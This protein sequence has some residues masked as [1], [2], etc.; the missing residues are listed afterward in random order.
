MPR[1]GRLRNGQPAPVSR[2]HA[3]SEI[4][5]PHHQAAA[6]SARHPAALVP[7]FALARRPHWAHMAF[8]LIFTRALNLCCSCVGRS[9]PGQPSRPTLDS[10]LSHRH[11]RQPAAASAAI[12]TRCRQP[13]EDRLPPAT[14]WPASHPKTPSARPE[15]THRD[16]QSMRRTDHPYNESVRTRP[17]STSRTAMVQIAQF[18]LVAGVTAPAGSASLGPGH[19]GRQGSPNPRRAVRERAD[20]CTVFVAGRGSF[21]ASADY[22]HA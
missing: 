12:S 16:E 7:I 1:K 21:S 13:P 20:R 18:C 10:A 11:A 9:S 8:Q 15:M 2:A 3:S 22:R 6:T 5:H 17:S 14:R 19:L 4:R